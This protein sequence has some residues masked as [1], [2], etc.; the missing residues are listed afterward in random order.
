MSYILLAII[1]HLANAVAF[2]IDKAL[3]T[4]AFKRSATYAA[5]IGGLS[6]LVLFAAPWVEHWPSIELALPIL[7][8]GGFF[9]FGLWAFFEALKRSE[10]SQ[11]VPVVGSLIPLFTLLGAWIL[12][13]ERLTGHQFFGFIFLIAATVILTARRSSGPIR[14]PLMILSA[15]LFAVSFVA[16]KFAYMHADFLGVFVSSRAVAGILG[17]LI[18]LCYTPARQELMAIF[19]PSRS[20]TT[21]HRRFTIL[22]TLFGQLMGAFGFILINIAIARGSV[23]IVNALQAVQY[24]AIVLV[25][26]F[27]TDRLRK[28]LNEDRKPRTI[29][30]K[31]FAIVLIAVGLGLMAQGPAVDVKTEYGITWSKP[32]AE[33]LGIDPYEGLQATLDDL[34]VRHF[35]IPVYWSEIEPRAGEFEWDALTH[36][37]EMIRE[38]GGDIILVIGAKQPRWPEWWAP[39]WLDALSPADQEAAQLRYV[40]TVM[41]HY[42]DYGIFIKAW[43]VENEPRFSFGT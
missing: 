31:S 26:W 43:Q 33:S 39:K 34:G 20:S 14:L 27:A 5:M 19:I 42:A 37:L 41:R 36:Q 9:V 7:A 21:L 15:M 11:V 3:L 2:I 13:G 35:R 10:A 38:R 22:L 32:Y 6:L 17:L 4:S 29:L 16:G 24:A 8:Y 30:T 25:A 18:G 23:S 12:L 40:E 1:G 28:L